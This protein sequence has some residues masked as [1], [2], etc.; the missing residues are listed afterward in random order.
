MHIAFFS[1]QHPATL[2][3][4]Q[5]SLGL[6]RK[7]LESAGHRVTICAP[8]SRV[9]PSPMHSRPS[10]VLLRSVQVGDHAFCLAGPAHDR[11]V[12]QGFS[13]LPPVDVVHVQADVWGAWNGYRFARRHGIPVVHTM[14]TNVELGLP[15]AVPFA[16]L[17]FQLLF[18]MQEKLMGGDRVWDIA[19]YV[20]SFA[21]AADRV[22]VP[23][24][25]FA[26]DLEGYGVQVPLHVIPTGVDDELIDA[27]PRRCARSNGPQVLLWA[28]RISEE[29]RLHEVIE[30]LALEDTP[31]ELHVYGSGRDEHRCRDLSVSLGIA[32]RVRFFGPVSHSEV[33][34]AMREADAVLQSSLGFE[35][36][37]LTVYE[38]ISVGTP[39]LVRDPD[40]ADDLPSAWVT[41]T[42]DSSIRELASAI[43]DLSQRLTM[44]LSQVLPATPVSYRQ[45]ELT[46]KLIELYE[47]AIA[48]Q[49]CSAFPGMRLTPTQEATRVA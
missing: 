44:G 16:R 36:Q 17:A 22:V 1:D 48:P 11:A 28:G 40:V 5:V 10:D 37:G 46:R 31:T 34:D 35:T 20:R 18:K 6:Q 45:S 14:H 43:R 4:L 30:A 12:D 38:A 21:A 23:S 32:N 33:I 9:Q 2:G 47:C 26:R 42:R 25:H 19:S 29:K 15:A 3:G 8:N 39:V 41:K 49:N 24:A 7:Y 13:A 27:I